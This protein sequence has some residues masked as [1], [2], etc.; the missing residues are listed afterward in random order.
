MVM[1]VCPFGCARRAGVDLKSLVKL[2]SS[3]GE[4]IAMVGCDI[5]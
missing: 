1:L 3:D 4:E 2:G 5:V